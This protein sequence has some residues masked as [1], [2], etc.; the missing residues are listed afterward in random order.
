MFDVKKGRRGILLLDGGMLL[1][2]LVAKYLAVAMI[3]Y[4]PDCPFARGG[5]TCPSCG[6][7]RCVRELF[8]GHWAEAFRLHPFLFCL[9]F[10]LAGA[11]VLLNVGY[12]IPQ[13]QCQKVGKALISGKAII[14]LSILYALF[15]VVR[16]FLLM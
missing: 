2:G 4:W 11:L 3:R 12:L 10:Y 8:S 14:I 1:F 6:A 15:G 7:T 16:M 9:S 5:I 13:P